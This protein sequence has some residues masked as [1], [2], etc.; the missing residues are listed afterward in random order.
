MDF[1]SQ[2]REIRRHS[3][4]TSQLLDQ[5]TLVTCF[6]NRAML[7]FFIGGITRP[8]QVAGAATTEDQGLELLLRLRP[9]LLVVSDQLE[10]GCG[11]RLVERIKARHAEVRTLLVVGPRQRPA[12]LRAALLAGCDGI[13]LESRIAIDAGSAALGAI[14]A[15]GTYIDRR[16]LDLISGKGPTP[17]E[18][19]AREIQVLDQILQG[20]SNNEIGANLFI[21]PETVKSHITSV[22]NKLGARDRTHAVVRGL[23]L[24]LVQLPQEG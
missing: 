4:H 2:I 7:G 21:S 11:C 1:T 12:K 24:G 20:C 8:G 6:G 9:D 23:G 16:L 17:P 19:S 18:L 14:R 13:C 22:C 3:S 5:L 15:G 10:Q